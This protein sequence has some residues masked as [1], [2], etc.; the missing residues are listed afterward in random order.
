[1]SKGSIYCVDKDLGYRTKANLCLVQEYNGI[2][3]KLVT[4]S[5]GRIVGKNS[6]HDQYRLMLA[7]GSWAEGFFYNWKYTVAGFLSEHTSS[8]AS[9]GVSG[10]SLLQIVRRIK[11]ESKF[12]SNGDMIILYDSVHVDMVGRRLFNH[13][14][15]RPVI[16]QSLFGYKLIESNNLS[17]S[18][19]KVYRKLSGKNN[20]NVLLFIRFI[21]KI[22]NGALG[23]KVKSFFI[24]KF[25]QSMA[26]KSGDD[27][28]YRKYILDTC[29]GQ[30]DE[31]AIKNNI[32]IHI[33]ANPIIPGRTNINSAKFDS[34]YFD[35]NE[36]SKINYYSNINHG[37]TT[38][39]SKYLK[40]KGYKYSD[41]TSKLLHTDGKHP[42]IL[43]YNLMSMYIREQLKI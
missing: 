11:Q 28:H 40:R 9:I 18:L 35:K 37:M 1:M 10:Y 21:A 29:M 27:F 26:G 23:Y 3:R 8:V 17:E 16:I 22:M 7:G 5:R 39:W 30:L 6:I 2:C 13:V 41:V 32:K 12:N 15:S 4:D 38:A 31:I 19:L 42:N 25:R 43:G 36:Y 14:L 33:F 34:Q 20:H 24:K